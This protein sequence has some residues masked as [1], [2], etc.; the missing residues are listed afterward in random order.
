MAY[1]W[2]DLKFEFLGRA[3]PTDTPIICW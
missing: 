2:K 3:T 1:N